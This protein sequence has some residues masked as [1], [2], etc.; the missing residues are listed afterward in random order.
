MKNKLLASRKS[1]GNIFNYQTL[2]VTLL[3]V[4]FT[5]ICIKWNI[6][7]KF[8]DLLIGM[9]IVF[10]I[11]FSIGSAFNR[12]EQALQK[13]SDF[14]GHLFSIYY[15]SKYWPVGNN[16]NKITSAVY[17]EIKD[18]F[19]LLKMMMQDRSAWI[20]HEKKMYTHFAN[21]SQYISQM[22][23]MNVQSGEISRANQ[24][25]SKIIIA[26]DGIKSICVYRTP[27]SLRIFSK[28]FIF[29]FPILY[30]PYFAS[31]S[32][33][34]SNGL[35]FVMPVLYSF[36]LISLKNIQDNLENPFDNIGEDD[37]VIN[38]KDEISL[39]K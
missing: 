22:R 34:Y 10:P 38:V 26:F 35:A 12:R 36:I 5:A 13:M 14:K 11:V 9:A 39:L 2:V 19:I 7:A 20:N 29:S 4:V 30:A 28:V 27:K 23:E 21:L 37:I 16:N 1:I 8:P 31:I 17:D 33:E 24:Y 18:I 15:A 25:I 32:K 6:T 3:S